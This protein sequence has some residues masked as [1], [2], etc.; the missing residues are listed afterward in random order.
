MQEKTAE[1]KAI[2]NG[3]FYKL[4]SIYGGIFFLICVGILVVCRKDFYE[5]VFVPAALAFIA[6]LLFFFILSIK[7]GVLAIFDEC[8]TALDRAIAGQLRQ[9]EDEETELAI[10]QAKL[11]RFVNIQQTAFKN[12]KLQK[13]QIE[14]LLS[15]ISH[16]TKTPIANILIY[17]QLLPV[18]YTH[19]DVYKRQGLC[20]Q[21]YELPRIHA[22]I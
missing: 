5:N 4:Y 22:C 3:W 18:S 20:Y 17:S 21:A 15:D 2:S 7:K 16:Q 9:P 6:L 8:G 11:A 12:V 13:E 19:L 10:F 1:K 14:G